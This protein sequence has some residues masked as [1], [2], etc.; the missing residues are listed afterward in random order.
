MLYCCFYQIE[1]RNFFRKKAGH[2]GQIS[3]AE[4][5]DGLSSRNP[6]TPWREMMGIAVAPPK[7]RTARIG[8]GRRLDG[9]YRFVRGVMV[10]T[11]AP[12]RVEL[13]PTR[14]LCSPYELRTMYLR[15]PG[16]RRDPY[17][18]ASLEAAYAAALL[19]IAKDCGYGFLP[20]QERPQ[21]F[22]HT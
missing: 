12:S 22:H 10:G 20:A 8:L 14:S 19:S 13:A 9:Y 3:A 15:R 2:D 17:A 6:S 11:L 21:I 16:E 4:P 18:V 5:Q 7:L 1:K